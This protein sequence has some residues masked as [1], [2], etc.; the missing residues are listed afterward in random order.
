VVEDADTEQV[1]DLP[2]AAGDLDV[3]LARRGVAAGV[4]VNVL[5]PGE[6]CGR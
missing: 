4:V 2:E 1:A 3:L 5:L 6:L